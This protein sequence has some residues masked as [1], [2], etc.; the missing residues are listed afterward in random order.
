MCIKVPDTGNVL[1]AHAL[2][3][4]TGRFQN[5]DKG[6][7]RTTCRARERD[8][9]QGSATPSSLDEGVRCTDL[10]PPPRGWALFA[11]ANADDAPHLQPPHWHLPLKRCTPELR[12]PAR[13][14]LDED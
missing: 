14:P 13:P 4:R 8:M 12:R 5:R 7:A 6:D 9:A 1:A 3:A 10:D 11:R 2:T